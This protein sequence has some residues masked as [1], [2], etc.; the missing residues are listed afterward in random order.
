M[1]FCFWVSRNKYILH[2]TSQFFTKSISFFLG[3]QQRHVFIPWPRLCWVNSCK[4]HLP[5]FRI[6][7]ISCK[8]LEIAAGVTPSQT[9][10]SF[11]RCVKCSSSNACDSSSSNFRLFSAH[12]VTQIKFTIVKTFM[13]VVTHFARHNIGDEIRTNWFASSADIF[14]LLEL[15][16]NSVSNMLLICRHGVHYCFGRLLNSSMHIIQEF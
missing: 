15:V 11:W 4:T 8:R 12:S 16:E 10:N 1:I 5:T 13:P 2:H 6:F 7:S 9:A 14:P 3:E